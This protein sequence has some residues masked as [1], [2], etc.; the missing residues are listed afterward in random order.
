[1]FGGGYTDGVRNCVQARA[2]PVTDV[3]DRARAEGSERSRIKR[4]SPRTREEGPARHVC[5][6]DRGIRGDT[7]GARGTGRAKTVGTG[8]SR[9]GS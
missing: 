5:Q 8:G 6:T 7:R 3:G 1:M 9:Q 2:T 4:T